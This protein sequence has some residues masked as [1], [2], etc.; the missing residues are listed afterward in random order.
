[1]SAK[2]DSEIKNA[3]AVQLKLPIGISNGD[4]KMINYI[5]LH[6][7]LLNDEQQ[8]K[9]RQGTLRNNVSVPPNKQFNTLQANIAGDRVNSVA[10]RQ[11]AGTISKGLPPVPPN[12]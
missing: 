1:M 10:T 3:N 5:Q 8:G 4:G 2:G 9:T 12:M 7:K 11:L 6:H